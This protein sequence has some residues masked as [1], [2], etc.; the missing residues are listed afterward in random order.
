[1]RGG[2]ATHPRRNKKAA[3]R[4]NR[5]N[6][7]DGSTN[8]STTAKS[9]KTRLWKRNILNLA[10]W[11]IGTWSGKDQ[12]IILEMN[13]RKIH[14]CALSETKKKGSGTTRVEDYILAY[15]GKPKNER[16]I[17]GVGL[18]IHEK[19]ANNI[20]NII[21]FN[22][23][24]LQV[25]LKFPDAI[26]CILS[27]YAPDISKPKAMREEFYED[28]QNIIDKSPKDA[29]LIIMGDMNA[30][31]GSSIIPGIKQRFNE[32]HMNENGYLLNSLCTTNSLRINNT[33]FKHKEQHKITWSNSRCQQSI[34]D[35][36]ITNRNIHP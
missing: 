28:L 8:I 7:P 27:V 30:R 10:T 24:I 2:L 34:I 33:F 6:K 18:L 32:D 16:A 13:H 14:I 36:I 9:R 20:D 21:Y 5:K 1:M 12:E 3:H 35:Y 29:K 17:A 22:E 11:N 19:Y 31:I 26:W 4:T 25:T 23:R 15:S